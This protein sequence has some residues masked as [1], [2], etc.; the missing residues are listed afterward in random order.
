MWIRIS[1]HELHAAK[2]PTPL[3][4]EM[5]IRISFHRT[6]ILRSSSAAKD[7][8]VWERLAF[9]S[10]LLQR[11]RCA[12]SQ[13]RGFMLTEY[14]QDLRVLR[15]CYEGLNARHGWPSLI[16]IQ[17]LSVGG[18]WIRGFVTGLAHIMFPNNGRRGG[19]HILSIVC[20]PQDLHGSG[21][22]GQSLASCLWCC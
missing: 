22:E 16:P 21:A 13:L 3:R 5:W 4:G 1:V 12:P 10:L 17:C 15:G 14:D 19:H 7:R 11:T 2:G 20:R 6:F 18:L 9:D 8:R